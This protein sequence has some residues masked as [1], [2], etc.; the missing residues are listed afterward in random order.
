MAAKE[1]IICFGVS[2]IRLRRNLLLYL[3]GKYEI[4]GYTDSYL[5]EDILQGENFVP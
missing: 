3:S 5:K 4:I 1:R 2:N